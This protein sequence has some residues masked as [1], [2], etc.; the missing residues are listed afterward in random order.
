MK[1]L[2]VILVLHFFSFP[3][4]NFKK[5]LCSHPWKAEYMKSIDG[6]N[7]PNSLKIPVEFY[8]TPPFC[9]QIITFKNDHTIKVEKNGT[10][11]WSEAVKC[12]WSM[13]SSGNLFFQSKADQIKNRFYLKV[14]SYN[15]DSIIFYQ[16]AI[17]IETGISRVTVYKVKKY[18]P[19]SNN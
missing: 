1:P 19:K 6:T 16:Q 2:L 3:A 12:N 10:G 15:N 4:E 18:T 9:G 17:G 7:D 13:D 8:N 14:L 5:I 11:L